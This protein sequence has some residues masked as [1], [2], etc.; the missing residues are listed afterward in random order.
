MRETIVLQPYNH[1]FF[2][3]IFDFALGSGAAGV[4]GSDDADV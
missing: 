2:I 4:S 3:Q 1:V